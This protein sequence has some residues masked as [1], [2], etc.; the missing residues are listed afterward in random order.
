MRQA[1]QGRT[2]LVL[3]KDLRKEILFLDKLHNQPHQNIVFVG[4]LF[5]RFL[6]NSPKP[7]LTLTLFLKELSEDVVQGGVLQAGN[8]LSESCPV[9]VHS[10]LFTILW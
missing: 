5:V 4:Q 7:S 1:V 3:W 2:F 8:C 10:T 6:D 9:V